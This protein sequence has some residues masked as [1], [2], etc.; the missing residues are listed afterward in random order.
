MTNKLKFGMLTAVLVI[1]MT[2]IGCGEAD[3]GE[4]GY[5]FDFQEWMAAH[6]MQHPRPVVGGLPLPAKEPRSVAFLEHG[7]SRY[8]N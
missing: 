4:S 6:N 5:I 8:C 7:K 1:G 3:D 2:V